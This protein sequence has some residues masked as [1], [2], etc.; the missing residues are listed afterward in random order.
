MASTTT[1]QIGFIQKLANAFFGTITTP[2]S[3]RAR[4][5]WKEVI[6][7]AKLLPPF[8]L[9]VVAVSWIARVSGAGFIGMLIGDVVAI[10]FTYFLYVLA[11]KTPIR[12]RCNGCSK[13]IL[14]NTPWICG[15]CKQPNKDATTYSFLDRCGNEGCG[16]ET[17]TYECHHCGDLIYLTEDNDKTN[18][19]VS[20]TI[21]AEPQI[22]TKRERAAQKHED[23]K[24]EKQREIELKKLEAEIKEIERGS[25]PK[26][27]TAYEKEREKMMAY[28]D[29]VVRHHLDLNKFEVDMKLQHK[30]NPEML[31]I[32]DEAV[33]TVRDRIM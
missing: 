29:R 31:K 18:V 32:I 24:L 33:R 20:M 5:Q 11:E 12:I 27:Q 6:V 9:V 10:G 1:T 16:I 28:L 19:A 8:L 14:S 26:V 30:D 22:I 25:D 15:I 7:V 13:V 3:G 23:A 4:L 17:K 21:P 2:L